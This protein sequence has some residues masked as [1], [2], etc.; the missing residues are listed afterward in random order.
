VHVAVD[1]SALISFLSQIYLSV[2][3]EKHH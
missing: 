1:F 2:H 3:F